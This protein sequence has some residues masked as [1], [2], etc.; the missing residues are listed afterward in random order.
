MEKEYINIVQFIIL[1]LLSF[2]KSVFLFLLK[3][4][5]RSWYFYYCHDP[6]KYVL[7]SYITQNL[8]VDLCIQ[9]L[10][11]LSVF[12]CSDIYLYTL[13]SETRSQHM[14]RQRGR[15]TSK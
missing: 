11:D 13:L 8:L 10:M 1:A 6:K 14:R 7:S 4:L 15:K 5:M 9:A 2:S 12:C 3:M